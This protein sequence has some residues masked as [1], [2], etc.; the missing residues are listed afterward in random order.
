MATSDVTIIVDDWA[1]NSLVP[2]SFTYGGGWHGVLENS[3]SGLYNGTRFTLNGTTGSVSWNFEGLSIS[4]FG[5]TP[6]PNSDQTFT[7]QVTSSDP[8]FNINETVSFPSASML[9]QFYTSPE[10]PNPIHVHLNVSNGTVLDYFLIKA[11]NATDLRNQTI[12]VDDSSSEVYYTG[13]WTV[14]EDYFLQSPD[15]SDLGSSLSD[16]SRTSLRIQPHGN[17]THSSMTVGDSFTFQFAG[18]SILVAGIYPGFP[19]TYLSIEFTVDS[20]V[21]PQIFHYDGSTSLNAQ[22]PHFIYFR[23]DSLNPGNHTLTVTIVQVEGN[24][25]ATFDYLTY[26]PSFDTI[27]KKPIFGNHSSSD[28][29][30]PSPPLPGNH[31]AGTIAGSV[32]GGLLAFTLLGLGIFWFIRHRKHAQPQPTPSELP[33]SNPNLLIEPFI[34]Q[35]PVSTIEGSN[36]KEP[37]SVSPRSIWSNHNDEQQTTEAELR[38]Q[39]DELVRDMHNLQQSQ[40]WAQ[41]F[42]GR[43]STNVEPN[44]ADL[45][46]QMRDMQ[47]R[48]DMITR[49]MDSMSRYM[50]PPAYTNSGNGH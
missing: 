4:F 46:T 32:I 38:Q 29:M 10:V 44:M 36:N 23:N 11:S 31:S 22:Y 40:S 42:G 49:E 1:S 3:A 20:D 47:M 26:R 13:N 41:I 5:F 17:G 33:D 14:Q 24:I 25:S 2:S 37:P 30:S 39:R 21:Y 27:A 34:Y 35:A 50:V 45:E 28:S 18:S 7:A 16:D 8:S 48:V 9:G 6:S 19:N 15:L 12:L 43:N